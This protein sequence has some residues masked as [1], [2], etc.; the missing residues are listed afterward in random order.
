MRGLFSAIHPPHTL[1][2]SPLTTF[3]PWGAPALTNLPTECIGLPQDSGRCSDLGRN[4][5]QAVAQCPPPQ[6]T[7]QRRERGVVRQGPLSLIGTH[8]RPGRSRCTRAHRARPSAQE[9]D[10]SVTRTPGY[11]A[12]C[13]WHQRSNSSWVPAAPERGGRAVPQGLARREPGHWAQRSVW[14]G[15]AGPIPTGAPA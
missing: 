10:R 1:P 5:Q 7:L 3:R 11:P 14:E 12:V 13:S 4:H 8:S 6:P 2:T 15:E 9:E